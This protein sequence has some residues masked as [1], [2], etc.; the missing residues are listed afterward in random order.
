MRLSYGFLPSRD[1]TGAAG[2]I[3]Y[4]FTISPAALWA[5]P[6]I[7]TFA[8]QI[9]MEAGSRFTI[10]RNLGSPA[11]ANPW[12]LTGEG[13][14]SRSDL[15]QDSDAELLYA[16]LKTGAVELRRNNFTAGRDLMIQIYDPLD[17][18][19]PLKSMYWRVFN[20]QGLEQ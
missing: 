20:G 18:V 16:Y 8:L 14:L 2:Q 11:A 13:K 3:Y 9:R 12:R 15:T 7:G 4:P 5:S 19:E 17:H 1:S 10:P 6:S